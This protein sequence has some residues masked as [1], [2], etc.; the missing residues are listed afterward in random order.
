MVEFHKG[1]HYPEI[2]ISSDTLVEL[3]WDQPEDIL[4]L[5]GSL[6]VDSLDGQERLA[7][8][9]RHNQ[10]V[11]ELEDQLLASR[12]HLRW[13]RVRGWEVGKEEQHRQAVV[14][15]SQCVDECGVALSDDM[16][17]GVLGP[18]SLLRSRS[19]ALESGGIVCVASAEGP[20]N[21]LLKRL[22]VAELLEERLVE[23][24]LDVL[25]V[26]EGG[27]CVRS[28]RGLLLVARLAGV[29]SLPDAEFAKIRE[30]DLKLSDRLR[31][32]D[33]VLGL[34]R[35]AY[36]VMLEKIFSDQWQ[37]ISYPSSLFYP[38]LL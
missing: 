4:S 6:V 1:S 31:S 13:D 16:V 5:N 17:Q 18:A 35:G 38:L 7:Q 3:V 21:L 27:R 26:V 20:S 23:Q 11:L 36:L 32:G 30:T 15:I 2:D 33:E 28:A 22:L 9:V 24:V 19:I 29:D 10:V 14:Q 25:G 8:A 37:Y 12:N 34:A